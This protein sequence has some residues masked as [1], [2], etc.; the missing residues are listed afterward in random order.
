MDQD[1][2][3]EWKDVWILVIDEI[4]FMKDSDMIQLDRRLKQCSG[5]R[6]KPFGGYSIIFAG[7]FRQ[8]EPTGA[9]P[10]QLLFSRESAHAWCDLLN[11]VVILE[12]DH[13][14]KEDPEYGKLLQRMWAGDLTKNDRKLL[15]ERVIGSEQVPVLPHEFTGLDAVYA[16]P[17][18]TERNSISAGNFKRHVLK[19]IQMLIAYRTRPTILLLLRPTSSHPKAKRMVPNNIILGVL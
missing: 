5:D 19:H 16:C 12:S 18:N 17:K 8:L 4:S 11:A 14:F 1:E 15:N 13:R 9:K 7:D 10:E 2:I 6:I 3:D